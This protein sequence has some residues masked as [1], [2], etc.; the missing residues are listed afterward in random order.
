MIFAAGT[1]LPDGEL[2]QTITRLAAEEVPRTLS[3][4]PLEREVVLD[5]LD[6]LGQE[7]DSGALDGLI[8]QYAP[9]GARE[10]L[11]RYA[12]KRGG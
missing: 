12:G 5:A 11:E 1:I 8:V 10:A 4:P 7:L 2:S 3:G 9:P 6:A